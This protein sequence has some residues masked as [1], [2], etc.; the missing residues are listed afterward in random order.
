ML[1][2]VSETNRK[3]NIMRNAPVVLTA[4]DK[5]RAT[6][7]RKA[8]AAHQYGDVVIV[9]HTKRDGTEQVLVGNI[10]AVVGATPDKEAV[11]LRTDKGDRSANL[12]RVKSI[13]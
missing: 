8:L 3:K 11:V 4:A 13:R 2:S 10:V 6:K 12:W 5:A 7:A 1:T 9:K